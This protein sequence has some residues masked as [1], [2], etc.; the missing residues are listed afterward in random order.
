MDGYR[1]SNELPEVYDTVRR[2]RPTITRIVFDQDYIIKT[3]TFEYETLGEAL[4]AIDKMYQMDKKM[5]DVLTKG[6]SFANKSETTKEGCF[7]SIKICRVHSIR[8]IE[9][10][11]NEQT[12]FAHEAFCFED[13]RVIQQQEIN[14]KDKKEIK[15]LLIAIVVVLIFWP[16]LRKLFTIGIIVAIMVA[17]YLLAIRR[18]KP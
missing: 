6:K 8:Y 7:Y 2:N 4:E 11:L 3:E 9:C 16:L 13:N 17:I 1:R 10:A 14:M 15:N 18:K 12:A 5:Y